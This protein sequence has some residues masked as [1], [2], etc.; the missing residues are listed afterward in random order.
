[1]KRGGAQR[2][3]AAGEAGVD[4]VLAVAAVPQTSATAEEVGRSYFDAFAARDADA[5]VAHWA[6]D[7]IEDVTPLRVFRGVGE[8]R[9]FIA[10]LLA[11][12]PD[13]ETRTERVIA[14]ER[15]AVVEWRM[16]G[17]FSGSS[18]E[19][20]EATGRPIELRGAD[21]LEIEDGRITRNTAYYDGAAFARQVGLLPAQESAAE[22]AMLTAFNGATKMRALVRERLDR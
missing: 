8:I 19:G 22:R 3:F 10:G 7:G 4:R 17:S 6:P 16:S 1:V 18:F 12:V 11:A 2:S 14:D 20:I 13:L 5:A 15:V 21:C 9:G